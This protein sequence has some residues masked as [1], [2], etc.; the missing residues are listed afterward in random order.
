MHRNIPGNRKT[1]IGEPPPRRIDSPPGADQNDQSFALDR[2]SGA[3]M[4]IRLERP[5]VW[6]MPG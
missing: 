4:K 3:A 2:S 6:K 1:A 5:P